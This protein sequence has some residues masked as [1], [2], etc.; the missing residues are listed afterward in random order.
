MGS[1]LMGVRCCWTRTAREQN[2]EFS[3]RSQS[4]APSIRSRERQAIFGG[5]AGAQDAIVASPRQGLKT[6]GICKDYYPICGM[7]A[8][9]LWRG[10]IPVTE[11][12]RGISQAKTWRPDIRSIFPE[13]WAVVLNTSAHRNDATKRFHR[14]ASAHRGPTAL[15]RIRHFLGLA[16]SHHDKSAVRKNLCAI[17]AEYH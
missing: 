14:Y 8:V 2:A 4:R 7:R 3:L 15:Q 6:W 1:A 10:A 11:T 17:D 16:L 5:P 13:N 12:T 9:A